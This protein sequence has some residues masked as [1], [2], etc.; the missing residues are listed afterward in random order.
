MYG[1]RQLQS[2]SL[3]LLCC[4]NQGLAADTSMHIAGADGLAMA[5]MSSIL[6]MLSSPAGMMLL[7]ALSVC[8]CTLTNLLFLS[9]HQ[10]SCS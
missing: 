4:K 9:L 7:R 8:H 6:L 5:Y 2:D 10:A 1:Q 3:L